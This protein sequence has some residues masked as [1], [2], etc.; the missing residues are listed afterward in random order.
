MRASRCLNVAC[1]LEKGHGCARGPWIIPP[2]SKQVP[3]CSQSNWNERVMLSAVQAHQNE[4]QIRGFCTATEQTRVRRLWARFEGWLRVCGDWAICDALRLL[5]KV[6]PFWWLGLSTFF[7]RRM[8]ANS[9]ATMLRR[10]QEGR[11]YAAISISLHY[12][13]LRKGSD[14]IATLISPH[15]RDPEKAG[16]M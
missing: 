5:A 12:G 3:H 4:L 13:G 15:I 1:S 9:A 2:G 6:P 11:G 14:Y 16:V 10:P 7:Q 8:S